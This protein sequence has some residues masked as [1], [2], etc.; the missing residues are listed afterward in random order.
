MAIVNTLSNSWK[1]AQMSGEVHCREDVF[2]IALMTPSFVFNADTH[3]TWDQVSGEEIISG[4]G[5]VTGGHILVSGEL[6][7]N[8]TTDQSIMSWINNYITAVDG[9]IAE[10]GSAI[11]YDDSNSS[12]KIMGCSDFGLDYAISSGMSLKFSSIVLKI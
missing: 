10:T 1:L 3:E 9:S 5:Y 11:I 12:D 8:N 4:N 6:T 2:K 7:Q